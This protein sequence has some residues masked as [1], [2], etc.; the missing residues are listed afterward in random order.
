MTGP[1]SWMT[2]GTEMFLRQVDDLTDAELGA[3]STLPG[4]S[5]KHVIAHVHYN[6]EALRRLVSWAGTGVEHRMYANPRQ[7]AEE[8]ESGALLAP[9]AL[10]KLVH[11]SAHALLL[12]FDALPEVAGCTKVITAQGRTVPAREIAW[13]RAREVIVHAVDLATGFS[14]SEAPDAFLAAISRDALARRLAAGEGPALAALLTGR[15]L[16]DNSLGP[17]L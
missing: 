6:A 9:T 16:V 17:W 2:W 15:P 7:R 1:S 13:L 12:E 3:A 5:R 10:R 4:W 14:F 11:Q 8:I